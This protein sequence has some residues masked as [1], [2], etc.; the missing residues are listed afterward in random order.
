MRLDRPTGDKFRDRSI[1]APCPLRSCA[2]ADDI[3]IGMRPTPPQVAALA[4][5]LLAGCGDPAPEP[6]D[7]YDLEQ[8]AHRAIV[9]GRPTTDDDVTA[10]HA[11]REVA[12][13]RID[14]AQWDGGCPDFLTPVDEGSRESRQRSAVRDAGE[15]G[16]VGALSCL[17]EGWEKG[18]S[19]GFRAGACY[20]LELAKFWGADV[21]A[22]RLA[23]LKASISE[24]EARHAEEA[25]AER[26]REISLALEY[27]RA[28]GP[29]PPELGRRLTFDALTASDA[30]LRDAPLDEPGAPKRDDSVE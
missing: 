13:M 12:A 20:A 28:Q 30:L 25:A 23:R 2:A 8:A 18:T 27:E 26:F 19:S 5:L 7:P 15:L 24:N 10:V 22:E 3:V 29:I 6:F 1:E 16:N 14:A 21:D 11:A 17:A 4:M 9:E